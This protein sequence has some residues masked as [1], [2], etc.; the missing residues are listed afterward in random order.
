MDCLI[1]LGI[2]FIVVCLVILAIT[3]IVKR[4]LEKRKER[5]HRETYGSDEDIA[6]NC[7]FIN[8]KELEYKDEESKCHLKDNFTIHRPGPYAPYTW[9]C[10]SEKEPNYYTDLH[11]REL[12]LKA[13]E[14]QLTEGFKVREQIRQFKEKERQAEEVRRNKELDE[15]EQ[16]IEEKENDNI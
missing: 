6:K 7:A 8:F 1:V 3:E 4:F 11:K 9:P 5:V 15:L 16:Q 13:R 12:K 2:T 14:W 10:Y